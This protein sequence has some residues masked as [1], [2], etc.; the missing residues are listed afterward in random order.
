M[1]ENELVKKKKCQKMDQKS[2]KMS[3][4]GPKSV[5]IS[6]FFLNW[7]NSLGLLFPGILV[8]LYIFGI[9]WHFWM[10]FLTFLRMGRFSDNFFT[11]KK[12]KSIFQKFSEIFTFD[13]KSYRLVYFVTVSPLKSL[14]CVNLLIYLIS[15]SLYFPRFWGEG[16][17][18]NGEL[19]LN[20]IF[21]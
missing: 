17:R 14:F 19:F 21:V 18:S 5:K 11:L 20:S 2:I 10:N 7:T 12:P 6:D 8:N 15:I 4:I 16:R 13:P 9:I 3:E 1:S